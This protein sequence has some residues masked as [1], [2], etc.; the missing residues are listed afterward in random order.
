MSD[1]LPMP[2]DVE[3]NVVERASQ[4]VDRALEATRRAAD[5]AIDGVADKVHGLR[6]AMAPAV[7][8]IVAPFDAVGQYTQEAP[9]KALLA[10][11]AVGA[12]LMALISLVTRSRP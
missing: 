9:L 5:V 8:R 3:A 12:V 10:A 4:T 2:G 7:D 11:A 1:Q 6:D